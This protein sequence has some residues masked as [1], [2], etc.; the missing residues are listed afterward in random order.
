MKES[1]YKYLD[2]PLL[3]SLTR[4]DIKARSVV[5]GFIAGLHRSPY[6]GFSLDFAEHRQYVPGDELKH[7]DWKVLGKLDRYYIK[8]YREESSMKAYIFLDC[9]ASMG[10]KSGKISK[11]EYASFAATALSFILLGQ[12]D[13]VGLIAFQG[14]K[15]DILPPK[16]NMSHLRLILEKLEG[17]KPEGTTC[18]ARAVKDSGAFI[19]KRGL[20]IIISDLF[21]E[22]K[23]VLKSLKY[24]SAKKHELII[25]HLLDPMEADFNFK[26][27]FLFKDMETGSQVLAQPE[28]IQRE[29]RRLMRDFVQKY[30]MEFRKNGIDYNYVRTDEP[31]ESS[32]SRF[33]SARKIKVK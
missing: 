23:D 15:L 19:K 7:L 30:K 29:Y 18:L 16:N 22:P 27:A 21:D 20:I 10:Y 33:L 25:L 14:G 9:S 1:K 12:K 5:E 24:F 3:L 6:K 4:S 11:L 32:L 26:E 2:L 31:V 8:Q 17:L 28:V 13:S